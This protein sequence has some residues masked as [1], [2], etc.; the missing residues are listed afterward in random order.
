MSQSQSLKKWY[1]IHV[2]SRME[3]SVQKKILDNIA[4]SP[5]VNSFGEVIVPSEEVLDI[6]AGKKN[7][8]ERKFFPGYIFVNMEMTDDTWYLIKNTKGVA[9]F[10]GG[11]KN[12]PLPISESEIELILQQIRDCAEKPKP[13]VE[14]EKEE[15]VRIKDGPFTDFIGIVQN[16]NYEKSKLQIWVSIFGRQTSVELD[17]SQVEK[18]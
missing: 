11:A 14:F 16:A 4:K 8:V 9:S 7:L 17:F 15:N 1:V 18:V 2:A 13:K 3:K 6:K 12:S 5:L 10:V